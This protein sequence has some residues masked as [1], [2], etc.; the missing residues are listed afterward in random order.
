I[1]GRVVSTGFDLINH[2]LFP[3]R[4]EEVKVEDFEG[5]KILQINAV[6]SKSGENVGSAFPGYPEEEGFEA[7]DVPGATLPVVWG[8]R[9]SE[10]TG[11]PYRYGIM[12]TYQELRP[13]VSYAK[14]IS[15][16]YRYLGWP[17]ILNRRFE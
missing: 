10:S 6:V 2:G 17:M 9:R 5:V 13:K 8:R 4:L 11:L 12:I 15:I 16:N 1:P 3:I 14:E 7:E